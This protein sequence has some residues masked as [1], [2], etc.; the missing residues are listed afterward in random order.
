MRT[1]P[2]RIR[3]F[4]APEMPAPSADDP[5]NLQG[6]RAIF[7]LRI[8]R[9]GALLG[10]LAALIAATPLIRNGD[11]AVMVAQI[12]ILTLVWVMALSRQIS[13]HVRAALLCACLYILAVN[14]LLNFGYSIDVQVFMFGFVFLVPLCF[15]GPI[16]IYA[17][18]IAV[19]TLAGIGG[20]FAAELADP[21]AS[22]GASPPSWSSVLTTAINF[23]LVAG[24][25]QVGMRALLDHWRLT[26][27][28][29]SE[30]RRLLEHERITLEQRV[31]ER[32]R[33]LADARDLAVTASQEMQ[34]Q[35]TYL[36]ALHQTT[37]DLLNRRD[38]Q[39]VLQAIV[40]QASRMMDAPYAE[41]MLREDDELVVYACTANLVGFQGSRF[42]RAEAQLS[43]QAFDRQEPVTLD[44]YLAWEHHQPVL[45]GMELR[46]V[47][48]LPVV[49]HQQ[50]RGVLALG[51]SVADHRFTP[52]EIA[53]GMRFA[54][55][56]A[57]VLDN[58]QL[59]NVT[60]RQAEQLQV[61]NAELDS[62]SHMVAHELKTP[63]T[64]LNGN[65]QLLQM[66]TQQLDDEQIQR[67]LDANLRTGQRMNQVIDDMLLLASVRTNGPVP[68]GHLAMGEIVKA[69]LERLAEQ[70]ADL[71]PTF[72]APAIWPAALG[73]AP[74]VEHVW[75]NYLSN[76]IKYGGR[77]PLIEIGATPYADGT[78]R[79]WVRD[80]GPGLSPDQQDHLFAAFTRLHPERAAGYGIGLTVVRQIIARLGGQVGI[81]SAAG[82]GSTFFFTLPAA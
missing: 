56:A 9:V 18:L 47:A 62:F 81:E 12:L 50:S 72:R 26:W 48:D 24:G 68:I 2:G 39:D 10:T 54:Q 80:N 11:A 61:R 41:L 73:Y 30:S 74:W 17:F 59:Y 4:L 40:D 67:M 6:V 43:W 37:L 19:A 58:S 23:S 44:D 8:L 38:L 33:E 32:T 52:H 21:L 55:L 69:P 77:P 78:V 57:L 5:A 46:A 53:R 82:A 16:N 65:T 31:A 64:I 29:E 70:Y 15:D 25:V 66:V 75:L 28:R 49:V 63:L 3:H 14:E 22:H 60:R 51:R 35:N 27:R 7:L 36:A 79:F 13:Y 20:V 34:A 76:A 42:A 1:L 45:E 71:A